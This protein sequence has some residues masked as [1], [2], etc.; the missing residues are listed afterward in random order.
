MLRHVA[1]S[2][3]R[4]GLSVTDAEEIAQETLVEV[5]RRVVEGSR[6]GRPI[7]RPIAFLVWMGRNRAIDQ[8]RRN[9]AR[10]SAEYDDVLANYQARDDQIATLLASSATAAKIEQALRVARAS[11]DRLVMRVVG[12]WL[13]L[14]DQQDRVPSSRQVAKQIGVSHTAVNQALARFRRYLT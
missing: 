13:N 2:V 1:H 8:L 12:A 9:N 3:R 10:S 11:D 6:S 14:A 4:L 5:Y 7:E